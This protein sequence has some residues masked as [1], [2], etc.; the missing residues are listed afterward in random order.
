VI[1]SASDRDAGD[2][3]WSTITVGMFRTSVLTA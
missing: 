1:R 3:S 2:R